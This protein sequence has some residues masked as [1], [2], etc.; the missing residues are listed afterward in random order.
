MLVSCRQVLLLSLRNSLA[1]KKDDHV[2]R[3]SLFAPFWMDN[4][5]GFSLT[6]KDLD[7]P[8]GL[9]RMPFLRE[10]LRIFWG[11]PVT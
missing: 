7:A 3:L 10:C 4:R 11:M 6:F 5:T 8:A 9:D 2:C 1:T